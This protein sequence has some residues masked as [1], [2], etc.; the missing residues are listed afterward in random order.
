[1]WREENDIS[2]NGNFEQL[3]RNIK[4]NKLEPRV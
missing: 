1:M 2:K 4:K 3:N